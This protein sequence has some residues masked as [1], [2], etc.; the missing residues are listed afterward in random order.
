MFLSFIPRNLLWRL[1]FDRSSVYVLHHY[2]NDF[3]HLPVACRPRG[4]AARPC[5]LSPF[6]AWA[7]LQASRAHPPAGRLRTGKACGCAGRAGR[8]VARRDRGGTQVLLFA[9]L[10]TVGVILYDYATTTTDDLVEK[11]QKATQ[12]SRVASIGIVAAGKPGCMQL[13]KG[14][15]ISAAKP[16]QAPLPPPFLPQ[17][18]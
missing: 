2:V 13:L 10:P 4:R 5:C 17:P 14:L 6:A 11:V 1:D 18:P 7:A 15:E 8:G 9:A 12:G 16:L 3:G